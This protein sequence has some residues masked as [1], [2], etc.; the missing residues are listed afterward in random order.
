MDSPPAS[1]QLPAIRLTGLGNEECTRHRWVS[2]ASHCASLVTQLQQQV[3]RQNECDSVKVYKKC[4]SDE[5]AKQ[6]RALTTVPTI[7]RLSLFALGFALPAAY[8]AVSPKR[9]ESIRPRQIPCIPGVSCTS[10][11]DCTDPL[12]S[13]CYTPAGSAD[14][15]TGVCLVARLLLFALF[16]ELNAVLLP[17]CT[18]TTDVGRYRKRDTGKVQ[19][20][21]MPGPYAFRACLGVSLVVLTPGH[22]SWRY[23]FA[24]CLLN[25]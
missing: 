5:D 22:C 16:T 12:F 13:V 6:H 20:T 15:T 18:M 8:A 17:F 10:D 3:F 21:V 11:A 19:D 9:G 14:G 7:M 4:S 24:S 25:R 23:M 2:E 1:K